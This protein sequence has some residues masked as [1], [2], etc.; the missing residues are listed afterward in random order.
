MAVLALAL[1]ACGGAEVSGTTEVERVATTLSTADCSTAAI[2][3]AVGEKSLTQC[4]GGWASVQPMSYA[5]SCTECESLWLFKWENEAWKLKGRCNQYLPLV[6]EDVSMCG[7]LSGTLQNSVI[8]EISEVPSKEV[9]CKIW[10]ANLELRNISRTGC[11]PTES[12]IS[13][14][15]SSNCDE[16]YPNEFFPIG[17]CDSGRGV[18]TVQGQL[19]AQG[20]LIDTDGYFGPGTVKALMAFQTKNSLPMSGY[21]D[22]V[23]WKVLFPDQSVLPGS[24]T[25]GD[26]II[27][28]DE[29][30]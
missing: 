6:A 15:T 2:D 19:V 3:A 23:T 26:K 1:S 29:F 25:N 24:D 16:Y 30:K 17:H 22:E 14:I 4:F 28:P 9:A 12:A 13:Y 27:S 11:K 18:R 10:A 5:A 7:G 20:A 21:V 8:E